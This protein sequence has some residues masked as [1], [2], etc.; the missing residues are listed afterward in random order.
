M[1]KIS[2]WCIA[3]P[4]LLLQ[5]TD[6]SVTID[7]L[8]AAME[9]DSSLFDYM[10]YGDLTISSN[11]HNF[12]LNMVLE[13]HQGKSIPFIIRNREPVMRKD[14]GMLPAGSVVGVTR[15]KNIDRQHRRAEI[16]TTIIRPS[17]QR[18]GINSEAKIGL[19]Q[20]VFEEL[21]FL[22]VNLRV[23]ARNKA[24]QAA[25]LSLGANFIGVSRNEAIMLDGVIRDTYLYDIISQEFPEIKAK[26]FAKRYPAHEEHSELFTVHRNKL[27]V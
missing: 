17:V 2:E 16:G 8:L 4:R 25:L 6:F 3:T 1:Q 7:E 11:M 14:G 22:K 19:L 10:F 13:S 20:F 5:Q 26:H 15:L 18:L 27:F 24:S 9:N 21:G 12:M 23:D